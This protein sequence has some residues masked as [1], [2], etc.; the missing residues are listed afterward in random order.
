LL[1]ITGRLV[2][3]T[4]INKGMTIAYFDTQALYAG[5]YFVR[6]SSGEAQTTRKVV[7]GK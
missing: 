6:I 7:V 5:T 2:Q 3:K 4:Q 1:D